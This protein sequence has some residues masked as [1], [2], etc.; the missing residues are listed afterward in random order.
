M[1]KT[2]I[3]IITLFLSPI[4]IQ[5]ADEGFDD[6]FNEFTSNTS[7]ESE[8]IGNAAEK[9]TLPDIQISDDKNTDEDENDDDKNF[10]VI[11]IEEKLD[12]AMPNK[13]SSNN[14]TSRQQ[15][16][17]SRKQSTAAIAAP[18]NGEMQDATD[19]TISETDIPQ[20]GESDKNTHSNVALQQPQLANNDAKSQDFSE[21]N[22]DDLSNEEEMMKDQPEDLD[23]T[24]ADEDK[25][26]DGAAQTNTTQ[27]VPDA[28]DMSK[29]TVS[30]KAP[31]SHKIHKNNLGVSPKKAEHISKISTQNNN[32]A[33]FHAV[34]EN[35]LAAIRSLLQKGADI[36]AINLMTYR[37]PLMHA[38]YLQKS[39]IARYL[40]TR[41]A[42]LN[43]SDK[44][45]LTALHLA[46]LK[47]QLE[48]AHI[49]M[50]AGADI[51]NI[52]SKCRR[53][54]TYLTNKKISPDV[55]IKFAKR[56]TNP[57]SLL[58][59]SATIKYKE[60]VKMAL[61]RKA[62]VNFIDKY[63]SSHYNTPL[64]LSIINKDPDIASILLKHGADLY[65]KNKNGMTPILYAKATNDKYLLA[66][67]RTVEVN[68]QMN[69]KS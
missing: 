57:N 61:E 52:D 33:L 18:K 66:I 56:Y 23:N 49:L 60:G 42:N 21:K 19:Q 9:L 46:F 69:K 45:N 50:S 59:D 48:I 14:D 44:N 7:S 30:V 31:Q 58:I 67:L 64:M 39:E 55:L 16:D 40:I 15:S 68:R 6:I 53:P 3:L 5:A 47:N 2:L 29:D 65:L 34:E 10:P 11:T 20:D 27:E 43:Q 4:H 54:L 36:N 22:K 32:A 38:I 12:E 17:Q 63:C 51:E 37:T 13:D 41:G 1:L 35:N 24:P 25:I 8:N 62:Y 28:K 26:N